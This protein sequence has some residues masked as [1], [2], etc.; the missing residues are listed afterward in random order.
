MEVNIKRLLLT[1]L[2]A[3]T[4][5]ADNQPI[6]NEGLSALR[7]LGSDL[8]VGSNYAT[9]RFGQLMPQFRGPFVNHLTND[10]AE[11]G[12]TTTT[13][14]ATAHAVKVGDV[15]EFTT[16]ARSGMGYVTSIA[17]NS[18]TISPPLRAAPNNGDF[19]YVNAY[20]PAVVNSTGQLITTLQDVNG[21]AVNKA[22]DSA[23]TS[24]D[25][26]FQALAVR[27]DSGTT[28]T[29]TNGDYSPISVNSLGSVECSLNSAMQLGASGGSSPVRAEDVASANGNAL[30]IAGAVREDALTVNTGTSGDF[31]QL[32]ADGS[33]KLVTTLAPPGETWQA[34]S[35]AQTGTAEETIKA[36]VA[37][38][39]IYVTSVAC[40][41]TGAA[42][43]RIIFRDGSGG[44][45][46]AHGMVAAT[47][48][49][50]SQ[51][52]PVPLRLT[53]NTTFLFQPST[54]SSST[55]C[56]ANGYVGVN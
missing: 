50:F 17:T 35:A 28:F 13:I 34:C 43:T 55:T 38:N 5:F 26:G 44:T 39:R 56:C 31:T 23:H 4:A 42:A 49:Y 37:S 14:N 1:L 10:T 29:N 41:N 45:A 8:T 7:D 33:G 9:D 54:T 36:N 16:A 51:S 47:T 48:G 2:I 24:G 3:T 19:F 21:T 20:M 52:F 27:N 15:V 53:S 32:K 11:T 18:F 46:I 6:R 40:V 25:A 12:S 30:M 22:E